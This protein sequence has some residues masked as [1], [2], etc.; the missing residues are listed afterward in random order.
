MLRIR[1]DSLT[2]LA[3]GPGPTQTVWVRGLRIYMPRSN[4]DP[5]ECKTKPV[6]HSFLK[7]RSRIRIFPHGLWMHELVCT[8][9][10]L[11]HRVIPKF[12]DVCVIFVSG[13]SAHLEFAGF[14][15]MIENVSAASA[16]DIDREGFTASEQMTSSH[17]NAAAPPLGS[18]ESPLCCR[19]TL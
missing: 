7:S 1:S 9:A 16:S 2:H 12:S 18:P 17:G 5:S 13:Q 15:I 11:L 8:S 14:F 6:K 4:F 19:P 3:F 10:H